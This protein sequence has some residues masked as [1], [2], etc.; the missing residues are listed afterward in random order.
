M[1]NFKFNIRGNDYEVE[2]QKM[3]GT[4]AEIEVNGTT[5]Q[6]E[7]EHKKVASKTPILVRSAI[8]NPEGSHE[9]KKNPT[10]KSASYQVK[11]PL[12]GTIMQIFAKVG[13]KVK[14]NDRLLIYEAM[15]MENNL[16]AEKDG[17]IKAVK[18]KSGDNVMQGDILF[19]ME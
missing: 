7:I 2:I 16:V 8:T 13:D 17:E 4:I 12:P 6:V 5:Y 18:V 15:K 10:A 19:E 11:A 3:E 9:I 14:R 1:R